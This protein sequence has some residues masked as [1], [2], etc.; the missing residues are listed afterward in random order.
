MH[1]K[2]HVVRVPFP[3]QWGPAKI[4]NLQQLA[5]KINERAQDRRMI[6][7]IDPPGD[8]K[9]RISE[10]TH[11]VLP[12]A[13][14]ENGEV[15]VD[16]EILDTEKGRQLRDILGIGDSFRHLV[17]GP[18]YCGRLRGVGAG[19]EDAVVASIDFDFEP[20]PDR[21]VLDQINDAVEDE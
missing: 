5:D 9:S 11:V 12:T 18:L 17:D 21:T 15:L 1:H 4:E 14:V 2:P 7:Q 3:R 19:I 13:R 16:I 10:A 20:P 8:G 6:G